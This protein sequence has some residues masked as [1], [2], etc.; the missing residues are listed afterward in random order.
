[1][2]LRGRIK[3][4]AV[5]CEVHETDAADDGRWLAS[6]P[7][8]DARHRLATAR[9][10]AAYGLPVGCTVVVQRGPLGSQIRMVFP[11]KK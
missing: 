11:P 4:L 9:E 6:H 10:V 2:L 1:V 3:D 8:A 5:A 7:E